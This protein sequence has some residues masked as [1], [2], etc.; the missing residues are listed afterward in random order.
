MKPDLSAPP[1]SGCEQPAFLVPKLTRFRRGDRVL[2]VEGWIW[3]CPSGCTDPDD[4]TTPYQFS[5][6][7]LME[8]EEG[9]ARQLW[10]ERFGESMPP[11]QR[12]R[13]PEVQRT[14]RVPVLLTPSGSTAYAATDRGVSSSASSC[15]IPTGGRG[16]VRTLAVL[17][18]ENPPSSGEN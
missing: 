5:T 12:G 3:Q 4:G 6:F 10:Q 7:E 16:E 14:V 1:C 9:Q 8:W 15:R 18:S 13:R 17:S 11:S 2:P